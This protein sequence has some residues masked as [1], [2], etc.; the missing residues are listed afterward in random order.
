MW[1]KLTK[2]KQT[3]IK[4]MF[5]K[6][7]KVIKYSD[8][9]KCLPK[10]HSIPYHDVVVGGSTTNPSGWVLLQSE[11]PITISGIQMGKNPLE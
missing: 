2:V 9:L 6:L 3:I 8:N 1:P 4:L 11:K 10:Y 5:S 7:V